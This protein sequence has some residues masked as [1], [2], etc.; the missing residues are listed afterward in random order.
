MPPVTLLPTA[1]SDLFAQA[2][3]SGRI[4]LADR[5]GLLAAMFDESLSEEERFSIDRLLRSV[6]RGR[7]KMV[8]ELSVVI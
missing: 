7:V 1:L 2:T 6:C 5:Y 3:T 4:T 8:D